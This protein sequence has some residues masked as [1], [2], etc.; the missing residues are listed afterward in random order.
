MQ[1]V[2]RLDLVSHGM[3]EAMRKARFPV[4]EPLTEAGRRAVAASGRLPAAR[5]LTAPERRA[6]ET[7]ALLGLLGEQDDRLRD[8]DAGAW[9]GGELM[10]VPQDELYAWLTDP[11]FR[12]HGGETVVDVVERTREWLDDMAAQGVPTIAVTHPAVIR[13]ALLITLD[14]PSKSFWRIDIPPV[15]ITRLHYRGEWTLHFRS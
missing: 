15:S 11:K 9:R 7:A 14:A 3:T 6:V 2:L 4:D 12:G 5:V 8:L 10:S 13:A 1:K